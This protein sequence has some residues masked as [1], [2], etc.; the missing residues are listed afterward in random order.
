[1]AVN[2]MLLAR[3]RRLRRV[4]EAKD[5]RLGSSA[6]GRIAVATRPLSQVESYASE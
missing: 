2:D 5:Y 4:T 1:M 3:E 6:A